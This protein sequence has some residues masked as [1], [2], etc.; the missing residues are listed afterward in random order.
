M[1]LWLTF[2]GYT[3]N[4][5]SIRFHAQQ[6][7]DLFDV[8]QLLLTRNMGRLTEDSTEA[9][10]FTDGGRVQVEILLL[11]ITGLTLEG[12]VAGA[13]IDKHLTRNNT[14]GDTGGQHIEN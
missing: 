13:A 10:C 1:A 9:E 6:L 7:D 11:D 5:I 2:T 8:V 14:H 12:L 3:D 4:S